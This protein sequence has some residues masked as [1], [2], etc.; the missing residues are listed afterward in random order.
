MTIIENVLESKTLEDL[1]AS[2]P[3]QPS[4]PKLTR[5][6]V[7]GCVLLLKNIEQNNGILGIA[8]RSGLSCSQV[9][10]VHRAMKAKITALTPV[11]EEAL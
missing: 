11:V 2:K 1:Q 9:K 7:E 6:K 8:K 10:R 4:E 5:V 3:V